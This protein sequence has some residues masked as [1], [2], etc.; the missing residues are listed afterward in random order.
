MFLYLLLNFAMKPQ[1]IKLFKKKKERERSCVAMMVGKWFRIQF[2][3]G[4]GGGQRQPQGCWKPPAAR[5][6]SGPLLGGGTESS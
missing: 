2:L 1:N 5:L 6:W 4:W 3:W